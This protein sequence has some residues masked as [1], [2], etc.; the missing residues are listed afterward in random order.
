MKVTE[1]KAAKISCCDGRPGDNKCL[2]SGCMAWRWHM[3]RDDRMNLIPDQVSTGEIWKCPEC[4][5]TGD[6]F[7]NST[8]VDCDACEGVPTSPIFAPTGYCG[9]AGQP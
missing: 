9:L 2:G 3:V 6:L 4:H 8:R 1:K 7:N 5:G